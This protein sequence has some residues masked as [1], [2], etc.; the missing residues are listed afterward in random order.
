M[1]PIFKE[2]KRLLLSSSTLSPTLLSPTLSTPSTPSDN[3]NSEIENADDVFI[4]IEYVEI[5]ELDKMINQNKRI[6]DNNQKTH[7]DN[8]QKAHDKIDLNQ[9][10]NTK[11]ILDKVKENLYNAMYYYWRFMPEDY[12]LST[13]LDPRV[14]HI[15]NKEEEEEILCNKYNKYKEEYLPTPIESRTSFPI[16]SETTIYQPRLFAV[17]EQDQPKS[18]DEIA[19]YLKEDK[20]NF[21]QNPFEWWMNKKSKYPILA[22]LARIYLA[23]PATSTPSKRLFSDAENLLTSKRSRV[24]AELFKHIMFLKRNASKIDSIYS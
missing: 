9:L 16:L 11:D 17:F 13:I 10:F 22:R 1:H 14:K 19:E 18:S 21:T 20:I 23:V 12:L 2:I 6:Q 8:N 3:I 7:N 5:A 15:Y 24:N 4:L